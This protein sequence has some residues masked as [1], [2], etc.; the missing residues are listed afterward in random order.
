VAY[1]PADNPL[2]GDGGEMGKERERG[3]KKE[4]V[5]AGETTLLLDIHALIHT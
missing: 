1:I 5:G 3:R 4:G 2:R